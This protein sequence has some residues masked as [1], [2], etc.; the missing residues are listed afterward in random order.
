MDSDP[1]NIDKNTFLFFNIHK[2][3]SLKEILFERAISIESDSQEFERTFKRGFFAALIY[4]IIYGFYEYFVVYNYI[5][6]LDYYGR[7]EVNWAIYF[8]HPNC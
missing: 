7:P 5:R 4:S 8:N 6:L 1:N 3:M 2:I